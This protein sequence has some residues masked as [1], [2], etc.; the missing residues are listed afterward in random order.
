[1]THDASGASDPYRRA[2]ESSTCALVIV[3]ADARV[4]YHTPWAAQLLREAGADLVGELFPTLFTPDVRDRVEEFV[5]RLASTNAYQGASMEATC[6]AGDGDLRWIQIDAVNVA[7]GDGIVVNLVDTTEH[8]RE[9]E[10]ARDAVTTDALTGLKNRRA[11]Y[12]RLQESQRVTLMWIDLDRLKLIND[13]RG[14]AIG[15]EVIR[16]TARRLADRLPPGGCAY[17]VGGDEFAIVVPY[18]DLAGVRALAEQ[19][20][21][22]IR[23]PS[24]AGPVTASV[25]VARSTTGEVPE[26]LLARADS[27]VYDV[28][29]QGGNAFAIAPDAREDAA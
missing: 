1:M 2:N 12:E 3:G 19:V 9:L 24:G 17:R 7:G 23:A 5:R 26:Q 27:A 11:L 4:T 28:K 16:T 10:Q 20:L 29:K 21:E 15:D 22:S 14:H 13:K 6:G 18:T 25:G 8:R